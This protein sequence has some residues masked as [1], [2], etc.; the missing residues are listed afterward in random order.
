MPV[1]TVIR[2]HT[3]H[4]MEE[5]VRDFNN[6]DLLPQTIGTEDLIRA[7]TDR[8]RQAMA[9]IFDGAKADARNWILL[10]NVYG[11]IIAQRLTNAKIPHNLANSLR[12]TLAKGRSPYP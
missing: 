11:L 10:A 3:L 12:A 5:V 8:Q 1:L 2:P 7:W 9:A 4:A 6:G